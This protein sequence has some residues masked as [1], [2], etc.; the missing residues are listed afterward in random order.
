MT[1]DPDLAYRRRFMGGIAD[2]KAEA[3]ATTPP[4]F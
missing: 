4:P 2:A 1:G 3:R